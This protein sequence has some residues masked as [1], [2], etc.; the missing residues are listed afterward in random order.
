MN[1]VEITGQFHGYWDI[2]SGGVNVVLLATVGE[3]QRILVKAILRLAAIFVQI[4]DVEAE[5]AQMIGCDLNINFRFI[6]SGKALYNHSTAIFST[7]L[8]GS[9]LLQAPV[10]SAQST[11]AIIFGL[12]LK[13]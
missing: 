4:A 3:I 1:A 13:G 6:Y 5:V 10:V 12:F 11:F 2:A 8:I 7:Q 9:R